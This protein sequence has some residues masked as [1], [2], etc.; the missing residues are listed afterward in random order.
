MSE[1]SVSVRLRPGRSRCEGS[2]LQNSVVDNR[3]AN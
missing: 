1:V 3:V 2:E